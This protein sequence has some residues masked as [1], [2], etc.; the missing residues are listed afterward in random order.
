MTIIRFNPN[1][2][3][4]AVEVLEEALKCVKSGDI[5]SVSISWV[6]KNDTVCGDISS[7]D[8]QLLMLAS[9]ENT[10]WSF[11]NMVFDDAF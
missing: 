6:T 10:L 7:G 9:M 5:K 11:K 8:N 1:E 3:K 2:N 4:D